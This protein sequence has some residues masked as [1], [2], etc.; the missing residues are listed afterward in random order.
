VHTDR[1][2]QASEEKILYEK[3][4]FL[5]GTGGISCRQAS[6]RAQQVAQVQ[7]LTVDL[8]YKE[9]TTTSFYIFR[10]YRI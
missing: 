8:H 10:R 2:K 6:K 1:S 9:A 4:Q 7:P 3:A 5:F